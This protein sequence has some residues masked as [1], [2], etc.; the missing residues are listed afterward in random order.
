[1]L[2][3]AA[4]LDAV[5]FMFWDFGG[6]ALLEQ[7]SFLN[8]RI[9]KPLFG[10]NITVWDDVYHPLQTGASFDGEGLQ[11]QRVKLIEQGTVK[12]VT[13]CAV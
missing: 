2:E 8:D 3:P 13:L 6:S 12:A 9:G 4:V 1:M 7:R 5:G 11:R 10:E